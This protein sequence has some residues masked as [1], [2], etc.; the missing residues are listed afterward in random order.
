MLLNNW[1]RCANRLFYFRIFNSCFGFL[2]RRQIRR[3]LERALSEP[4]EEPANNHRPTYNM[5]RHPDSIVLFQLFNLYHAQDYTDLA[6]TLQIIAC[7][8]VVELK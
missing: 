4:S 7:V 1:N 2:K 5:R 6:G 3:A 8:A